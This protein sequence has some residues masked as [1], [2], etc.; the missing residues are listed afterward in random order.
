MPSD[1]HFRAVIALSASAAILSATAGTPSDISA[2]RALFVD[3]RKGNCAS[4]HR[5]PG[6][7][8]VKSVASVGPAIENIKARFP[9]RQVLLRLVWDASQMFPN[10]VMPP[11][12]R[13]RIL[14]DQ[15]I[16]AIV[17]YME[18]L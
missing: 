4:C 5:V 7:T 16:D 6:D 14:T 2:G 11:Y 9:D 1:W 18:T 17:A 8:A 12:G 15:E 10:T 13:H 3:A